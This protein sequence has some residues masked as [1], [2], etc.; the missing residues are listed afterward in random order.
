MQKPLFLVRLVL[1]PLVYFLTGILIFL[2]V[3]IIIAVSGNEWN[4]IEIVAEAYLAV[5]NML[6]YAL[7]ITAGL[8]VILFVLHLLKVR[9]G[10]LRL[11]RVL[12]PVSVLPVAGWVVLSLMPVRAGNTSM[13]DVYLIVADTLRQDYVSAE[14]TPNIHFLSSESIFFSNAYTESPWTL[15][16]FGSFLTGRHPQEHRAGTGA[17]RGE[18]GQSLRSDLAYL[19]E[20]MKKAGYQTVGLVTNAYLSSGTGM[21]RGFDYYYNIMEPRFHFS[22][23]PSAD[24]EKEYA[25]A[26]MQLQR[27]IT[28]M[29]ISV[30]KQKPVFMM[31]QFMDPHLPYHKRS[32]WMGEEKASVPGKFAEKDIRY[33]GEVRY[34]DDAIGDLL[35][36]LGKSGRYKNALVIFLSDHGEELSE[37]RKWSDS[38]PG[39]VDHGHSLYPEVVRASL[40]I[41]PPV[42]SGGGI[43]CTDLA[44]L[45]D[46]PQTVA[47]ILKLKTWPL[48]AGISLISSSG[49]CTEARRAV[50]QGGMLYGPNQ[51]GMRIHR[52]TVLWQPGKDSWLSY[53]T[54][55]DPGHMNPL[56]ETSESLKKLL[57]E[58]ARKM[59]KN[60]TSTP[61]IKLTREEMEH[62]RSLG[63]MR[64]DK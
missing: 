64:Q 54:E 58:H 56:G 63:Y 52:R 17:M 30:D 25:P 8:G 55:T 6:L 57:R 43:Q 16:S 14:R 35:S 49:S 62:L 20:E 47:S 28:W 48:D 32:P 12:I 24:M 41:K 23:S 2:T 21:S 29:K 22:W 7:I 1:A 45:M 38:V 26:R 46:V 19:P 50:F 5:E 11:P 13:P 44:T 4:W 60:K 9:L 61:Q 40:I 27:A 39:T 36:I 42:F 59:S 10:T 18:F 34:M 31:L 53:S 51:Y 37:G 33:G 3:E 15:T